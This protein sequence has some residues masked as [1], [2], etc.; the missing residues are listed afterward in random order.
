MLRFPDRKFFESELLVSREQPP[1]L[2]RAIP[3]DTFLLIN[4]VCDVRHHFSMLRLFADG[5][6]W[7]RLMSSVGLSCLKCLMRVLF[8]RVR[9]SGYFAE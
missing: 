8:E 6:Q 7:L 2:E 3:W 4:G 9:S 1:L 5:P